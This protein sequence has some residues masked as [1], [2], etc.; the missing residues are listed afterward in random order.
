MSDKKKKA[1]NKSKKARIHKDLEGFSIEVDNFGV[2]KMNRTTEE[3]SEFLKKHLPE[4]P[5]QRRSTDATGEE[6]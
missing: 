1:D 6:E 2:I 4:K 5:D 3:M